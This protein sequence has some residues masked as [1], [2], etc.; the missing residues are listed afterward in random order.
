MLEITDTTV[1][2]DAKSIKKVGLVRYSPGFSLELR[3]IAIIGVAP[4]LVL[5]DEIYFLVF[6]DFQ[7]QYYR[8]CDE[9]IPATAREK[10]QTL[11]H[12]GIWDTWVNYTYAQ[13]AYGLSNILYPEVLAGQPLFEKRTWFLPKDILKKANYA[14]GLDNC[15]G[16]R[17]T[18]SV[19]AYLAKHKP[20]APDCRYFT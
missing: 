14:L 7:G 8:V 18:P 2:F 9:Q 20:A 1:N 11:F 13:H 17:L 15:A 16:E 6:T 3:E 10:L 5:D 4:R 19:I 12:I